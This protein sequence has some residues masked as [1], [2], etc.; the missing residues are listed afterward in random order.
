MVCRCIILENLCHV[1]IVN[2][3]LMAASIKNAPFVHHLPSNKVVAMPENA[4]AKVHFFVAV[5]LQVLMTLKISY[6][7]QQVRLRKQIL[8][9]L[10]R[11]DPYVN[12]SLSS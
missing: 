2:V 8:L 3:C 11:H 1:N 6:R 12:N 10:H 4:I 5:S 9:L 7:P